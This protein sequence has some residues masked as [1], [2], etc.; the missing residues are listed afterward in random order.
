MPAGAV[1]HEAAR[2]RRISRGA[3]GNREYATERQE[4]ENKRR[5]R[6]ETVSKRRGGRER[7]IA[8]EAATGGAKTANVP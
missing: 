2:E 1:A 8:C 6:Q 5:G 4:P 3:A 7:A